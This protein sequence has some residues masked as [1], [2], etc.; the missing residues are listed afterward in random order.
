MHPKRLYATAFSYALVFMLCQLPYEIYRCILLWNTSI[1]T[2]ISYTSRNY[3]F[4]IEIPLLILK[5]LNRCLNPFFFICLADVGALRRGCCRLWCI[6][7][8]PGCIGCQK[9]WCYDCWRSVVFE[10]QHCCMGREKSVEAD[11]WVPT[12]LQTIS[13]HQYRDGERL[14]TK[15]RI[16]E[17]FETDVQPYY[18]NPK[19]MDT[20]DETTADI[21]MRGVRSSANGNESYSYEDANRLASFRA[22]NA[23]NS[24]HI[25]DSRRV[26]L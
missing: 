12:G 14:V 22:N 2:D 25:E 20:L 1:E 5:L 17:E 8:I 11:Q 26:K 19:R 6:P 18:K 3:D 15:Q 13:T 9:C 21:A 7:C 23:Q 24:T 4:A 16:V 10:C